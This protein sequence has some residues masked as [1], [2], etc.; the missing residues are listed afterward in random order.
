MVV[1]WMVPSDKRQQLKAGHLTLRPTELVIFLK[2]GSPSSSPFWP[3]KLA[4]ALAHKGKSLA[5][6]AREAPDIAFFGTSLV[7]FG[8]NDLIGLF[9]SLSSVELHV[10]RAQVL[11]QTKVNQCWWNRA[12]N[13]VALC[14]GQSRRLRDTICKASRPEVATEPIF[15][16]A[17]EAFLVKRWSVCLELE[18]DLFQYVHAQRAEW[19]QTYA[20]HDTTLFISGLSLN[21]NPVMSVSCLHHVLT[22][23]T[24]ATCGPVSEPFQL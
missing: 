4:P 18:M 24:S 12:A 8:T 11:Q 2:P 7:K 17:E 20:V 21:I 16:S 3:V 13:V 23:S 22:E 5:T 6:M 14:S 10:S 1:P 9:G 15:A 19:S